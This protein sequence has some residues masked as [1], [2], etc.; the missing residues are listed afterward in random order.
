MI[1]TYDT[2]HDWYF[3]NQFIVSHLPVA[4]TISML[5]NAYRVETGERDFKTGVYYA[6]YY[7][8]VKSV[9]VWAAITAIEHYQRVGLAVNIPGSLARTIERVAFGHSLRT[10]FRLMN[11]AIA[12]DMAMTWRQMVSPGATTD[13]RRHV[14]GHYSFRAVPRLYL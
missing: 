11:M 10:A 2:I 4:N 14:G 5:E 12:I 9:H 1:E 8:A 13:V 7:A 3:E 6:V